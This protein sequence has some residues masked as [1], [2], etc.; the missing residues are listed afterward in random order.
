VPAVFF[1]PSQT[2]FD[3]RFRLFGIPVRISPWFWIITVAMGWGGGPQ[4]DPH[5]MQR[6][7]VWIVCV[8]VSILIHELGHVLVGRLFGSD[9]HIIL[10]GMGGLAVG[11][12]ALD[13]RWQRIAVCAAGPGA[14]FLLVGLIWGGVVLSGV[15]RHDMP[16][17][18]RVALNDLIWINL[19][20]GLMNLL[21][22]WPLDGGQISRDVCSGLWHGRG[23]RISLG[24]STVIAGLIAV[25]AAALEWSP[26]Y[27]E[28]L[29]KL[30]QDWG[31]WSVYL[32]D[33]GG[34]Y[35]A[36][37]F[38]MLALSSWMALQHLERQQREWDDHWAD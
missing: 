7:A 23:V 29:E 9:G 22:V 15:N 19:V 17:M 18:A 36:L 25:H 6:L 28:R 13:R 3:L 10:Y 12:N 35:V 2:Q 37:F 21:P 33:L 14:D 27:E 20:W 26:A 1:E 4:R 24:I 5:F 16:L 32:L 34:W 30:T 8:F 38:G 11:S 31:S